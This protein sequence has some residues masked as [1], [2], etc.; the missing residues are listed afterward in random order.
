M[1]LP[2][3]IH[4]AKQRFLAPHTWAGKN[5]EDLGKDLDLLSTKLPPQEVLKLLAELTFDQAAR[6]RTL[7]NL[8]K[9]SILFINNDLNA[10]QIKQ[11]EAD[12][13]ELHQ[14][15]AGMDQSVGALKTERD[16]LQAH[17]VSD[18]QKLAKSLETQREQ[19]VELAGLD[20]NVEAADSEKLANAKEIGILEQKLMADRQQLEVQQSKKAEAER[21]LKEAR[22]ANAEAKKNLNTSSLWTF[23]T[24][25]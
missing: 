2:V 23:C 25:L 13:R 7:G 24:I 9:F 3:A 20:K 19:Q 11:H 12:I 21:L 1:S 10:R 4:N 5:N 14:K 15:L 8:H 18:Q 22:A 6:L 16:R 17:L